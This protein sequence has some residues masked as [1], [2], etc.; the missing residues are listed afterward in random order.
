M[1]SL[2]YYALS[3][4]KPI[5]SS[6]TQGVALGFFI[7]PLRGWAWWGRWVIAGRY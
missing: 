5:R 1:I 4:L 6:F 2:V 7:A 3:G